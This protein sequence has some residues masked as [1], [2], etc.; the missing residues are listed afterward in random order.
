MLDG[1]DCLYRDGRIIGK[2]KLGF[3]LISIKAFVE[4]KKMVRFFCMIFCS[5]L[6]LRS[7]I[8]NYLGFR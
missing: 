1:L 8:V 2:W 7:R 5:I 3:T 6:I 4:N